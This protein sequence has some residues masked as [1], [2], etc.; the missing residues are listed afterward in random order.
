MIALSMNGDP[1]RTPSTRR[2]LKT[3]LNVRLEV[4][5]RLLRGSSQPP[6]AGAGP[7]DDVMR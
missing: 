4:V 5:V 6:G 7:K 2:R 3:P 1:L